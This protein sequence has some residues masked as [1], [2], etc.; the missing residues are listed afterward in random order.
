MLRDLGL[1]FTRPSTKWS[2]RR[3]W[4]SRPGRSSWACLSWGDPSAAAAPL[5]EANKRISERANQG[6]ALEVFRR[7]L[8]RSFACSLARS[9]FLSHRLG[10]IPGAAPCRRLVS[11]AEVPDAAALVAVERPQ[12]PRQRRHARRVPGGHVRNRARPRG[13][14]RDGQ[15]LAGRPSGKLPW[16]TRW[17]I[18]TAPLLSPAPSPPRGGAFERSEWVRSPAFPLPRRGRLSLSSAWWLLSACRLAAFTVI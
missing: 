8:A 5:E 11:P 13:A 10:L 14:V 2:T 15:H 6:F 12:A 16:K 4:A 1:P 17:L 9:Y 18:S 7:S 3:R